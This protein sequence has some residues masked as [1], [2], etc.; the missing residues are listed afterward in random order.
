MGKKETNQET[1]IN[2][3]QVRDV[4]S[5]DTFKNPVLCAQFIRDNIN[6][7]L[8]KSVQPEDIEDMTER[9]LAYLGTEFESDSVKRIRIRKGEQEIPLY[10]ISLIEHK[11]RVDYNVAM[12]LL[13]YIVCIWTEYGKEMEHKK[14][15][16]T[17]TKE[18]RYPPI[19]PIVYYEGSE[20]WTADVQ[21]K[22]RVLLSDIFGDYLPDFTYNLVRIH[23]YTNEELLSRE[24]EMSLLMMINKVQSAEDMTAFWKAESKRADRILQK[25]PNAVL[26]IMASIV[27]GLCMK[28]NMP[29]EEASQCVENVKERHMGY[30]FENAEKMDIQEERRKT[31][32]AREEA[33][34]AQCEA[35]EAKRKA[36]EAKRKAEEAQQKL[37]EA[38]SQ[39][40][41][42]LAEKDALIA[43]LQAQLEA[44]RK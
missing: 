22:D 1:K 16:I 24:D 31:K 2:A 14:E 40:E 12:Q 5:K 7:P 37:D 18:F 20:K 26:E 13:K 42:V 28:M 35:E 9:Y 4:N 6:I 19:L 17:K 32:L 10:M 39:A 43:S 23:D 41:V 3:G 33:I 8:L 25:A 29:V 44:V 27:W 36:E 34:E 30:F 11:S 21:L 38:K 15:G